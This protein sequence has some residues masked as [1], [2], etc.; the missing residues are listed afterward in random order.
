MKFVVENEKSLGDKVWQEIEKNL[1]GGLVIGL[2]GDLGAGKTTLVRQLALKLGIPDKVVS[3]TFN[4][5]KNY[6]LPKEKEGITCLQHIDLY[7]ISQ[8]NHLDKS[9]VKEW[10]AETNCLTF[11]EW[12]DRMPQIKERLDCIINIK[13]DSK[14]KREVEIEWL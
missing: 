11:I 10:L 1:S 7:R 5:R 8:P 13:P 2:K 12:I 4:I 14:T 9:E 6:D 3:P